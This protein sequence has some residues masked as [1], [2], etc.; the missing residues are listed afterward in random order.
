M[1]G[2]K[3]HAPYDTGW[4]NRSDWT[5][6][7]LGSNTTLNTDSNVTHS[8]NAPLANLL[9]KLFISTDG[10]DANSYEIPLTVEFLAAGNAAYGCIA[11]AVDNNNLLLQTGS[12]GILDLNTS[13]VATVIDTEN[14]YYKVKVWYLG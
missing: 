12:V 13:G 7:H 5:N 2:N 14:Y 8:L 4:I 1:S 10:T 11:F 3:W 9:V 6:V